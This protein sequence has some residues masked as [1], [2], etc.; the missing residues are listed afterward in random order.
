[1]RMPEEKGMWLDLV[2]LEGEKGRKVYGWG[3]N[4]GDINFLY[5]LREFFIS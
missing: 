2:S 5:L 4:L 3:S 1:M